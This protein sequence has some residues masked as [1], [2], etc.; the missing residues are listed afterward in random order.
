MAF[1]IRGAWQ[2]GARQPTH[3]VSDGDGAIAAGIELVYGHPAL[4]QQWAQQMM[5]LTGGAAGYWRAKAWSKGLRHLATGQ[6][7]QRTLIYCWSG[8]LGRQNRELRRRENLGTV[9]TEHNRLAF[10]QIQGRLNQTT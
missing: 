4:H 9:W 10:Q 2:L 7:R 3:Q 1:P 6:I 8:R 5:G